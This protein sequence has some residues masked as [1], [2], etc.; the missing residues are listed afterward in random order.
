MGATE[1]P[2]TSHPIGVL[3]GQV[4]TPDAP[5]PAA[6]R[7]YL[8]QFLSDR[9]VVDYPAWLWQPFLR[10]VILPTRSRRSARLYRRI[11]TK[12][13]SPLLVESERQKEK[14]Q[15]R[16]GAGYRVVLG[17]AYAGPSF[18]RAF[19]ELIAAGCDRVIVVPMF[20]QYS[21]ATTASVYDAV[22]AAS[23]GV[24]RARVFV[25]AVS[26]VA[27]FYDHP[28]YIGA[29]ADRIRTAVEAHR[30]DHVVLSFHGLPRRYI[31][32]GD[33]YVQH[34]RR[35]V[36]L[37]TATMR[38]P[39]SFYTVSYQSRFGPEK[40]IEPSTAEVLTALPGRGVRR[41]LVVAPG[42]TTDCLETLDELGNEGKAEFA[43]A[44]GDPAAYAICPCLN[45]DDRLI[46]LL[47]SLVTR[48]ADKTMTIG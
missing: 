21:S 5:T 18:D 19:D 11:W 7:R 3:L 20:P 28:D 27:P 30:P 37:L 31:G 33:P 9:R 1:R 14:L 12:D 35:T 23:T 2:L 13:G 47:A 26:Y 48:L 16:L 40:W 10:L 32:S 29:L 17:M 44:G 36:E 42:F 34:C 38:W 24:A 45:A 41:P 22:G 6:V 25:P 43:S 46:E 4:G 8:G 39:E 15:Q